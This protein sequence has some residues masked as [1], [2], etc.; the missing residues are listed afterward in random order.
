MIERIR[1]LTEKELLY[2]ALMIATKAHAGQK[3]KAGVDY[4]YHPLYVA[5]QMDTVTEK[6]VGLLHDVV[7]DSD[8]TLDYLTAEGFDHEVID[9]LELL[10]HQ[11]GQSYFDYIRKLSNNPIAKKVKAVDL[12]HNSDISRLK[13][14]TDKDYDRVD[15]Y[16]KA[17]MILM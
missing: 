16:R 5:L 10:T 3:D 13:V 7:E 2:K 1:M 14:I 17:L 4:I 12:Q 6:I 15:K 11:K 9:A 8:I